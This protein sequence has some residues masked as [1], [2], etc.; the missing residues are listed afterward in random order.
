MV[1]LILKVHINTRNEKPKK[2]EKV[3]VYFG[4]GLLKHYRLW[5]VEKG[6]IR[7]G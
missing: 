2:Y 3:I 7:Y 1:R 6:V 4:Y 5:C